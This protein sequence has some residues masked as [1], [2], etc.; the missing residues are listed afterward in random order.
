MC[1]KQ[2]KIEITIINDTQGRN[3]NNKFLVA[4]GTKKLTKSIPKFKA[5]PIAGGLTIGP[6]GAKYKNYAQPYSQNTKIK[7]SQ[8]LNNKKQKLDVKNLSRRN[9]IKFN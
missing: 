8:K 2:R 5:E 1:S 4:T 6:T 7:N 9:T 3:L